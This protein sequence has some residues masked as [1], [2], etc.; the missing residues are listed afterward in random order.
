MKNTNMTKKEFIK[1][2][3]ENNKLINKPLIDDLKEFDLDIDLV[4]DGFTEW[5]KLKKEM[6]IKEYNYLY[7]DCMECENEKIYSYNGSYI[8]INSDGSYSL[9][10][11]RDWYTTQDIEFLELILFCEWV[12]F[13]ICD[14]T[15][16][17]KYDSNNSKNM[18]WGF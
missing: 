11:C 6:T 5:K 14:Y 4:F 2:I 13:E 17:K 18:S 9:E 3:K 1:R 12:L 10:L 8:Y 16:F 7:V 15:K